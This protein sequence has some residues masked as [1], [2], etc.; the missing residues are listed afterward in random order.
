MTTEQSLFPE[1]EMEFQALLFFFFY[2]SLSLHFLVEQYVVCQF[3][4]SAL[5][6]TGMAY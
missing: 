4:G 1:D 5:W 3:Q 6:L 2:W